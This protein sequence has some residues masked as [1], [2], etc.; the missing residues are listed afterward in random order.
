[1]LPIAQI[2][3]RPSE[4]DEVFLAISSMNARGPRGGLTKLAS[5]VPVRSGGVDTSSTAHCKPDKWPI[6][7]HYSAADQMDASA[8]IVPLIAWVVSSTYQITRCM[9]INMT[10][11]KVPQPTFVLSSTTK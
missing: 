6:A 9:Q 1:M 5:T 10:G 7:S 3:L 11:Q 8:S 4:E 2:Q